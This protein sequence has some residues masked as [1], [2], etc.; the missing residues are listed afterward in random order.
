[1][2]PRVRVGNDV[3]RVEQLVMFQS[4]NRTVFPVGLEHSFAERLLMEP[5][6]DW[7]RDI[8]PANVDLWRV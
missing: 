6:T 1:M 3:G 8:A 4:T 5:L 2:A 7:P